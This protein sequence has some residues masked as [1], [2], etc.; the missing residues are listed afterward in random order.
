MP[1]EV[2]RNLAAVLST[3]LGRR[4]HETQRGV[5]L[6]GH[7]VLRIAE[8][9]TTVDMRG[10]DGSSLFGRNSMPACMYIHTRRRSGRKG[11]G[12]SGALHRTFGRLQEA[13]SRGWH[14]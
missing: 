8:A 14:L 13:S 5:L 12:P 2:L 11:M 4:V 6:M 3:R 7:G 9:A 10:R 1:E